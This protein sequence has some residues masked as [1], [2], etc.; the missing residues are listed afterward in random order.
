MGGR[1]PRGD[2][3]RNFGAAHI[4]ESKIRYSLRDPN[5]RR[6]FEELGY[7]EEAGNW[8]ILRDTVAECSPLYSACFSH[9]DRWGV[10]YDVDMLL[11]GPEGRTAPVRTKWIFRTGED[12]PRLVT[13][14]VKTTEWRRWERED[15]S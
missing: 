4:P 15:R 8:R 9:E 6:T 2:A 11:T 14:Y 13:L 12:M 7:S 1:R 3:L 5:K 10:T